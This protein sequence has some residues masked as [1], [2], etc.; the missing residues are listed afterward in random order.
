M[1]DKNEKDWLE[2]KAWKM[3]EDK[4]PTA[5]VEGDVRLVEVQRILLSVLNTTSQVREEKRVC[6]EFHAKLEA[7]SDDVR[8]EE[9]PG[10]EDAL[11]FVMVDPGGWLRARQMIDMAETLLSRLTFFSDPLGKQFEAPTKKVE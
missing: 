3:V 10:A 1:P 4:Q 2:E 7:A 11:R 9:I 6:K 8:A 5:T